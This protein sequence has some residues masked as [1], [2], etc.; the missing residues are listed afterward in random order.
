MVR[1]TR[2]LSQ[3]AMSAGTGIFTGVVMSDVLARY[4]EN[5]MDFM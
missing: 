3:A 4:H 2:R 1:R 5:D